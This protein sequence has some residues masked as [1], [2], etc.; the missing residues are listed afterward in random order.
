[1][2]RQLA[3]TG[4]FVGNHIR[5]IG[6]GQRVDKEHTSND[7]QRQPQCAASCFQKQYQTTKCND[8]VLGNRRARTRRKLV[9]KQIQIRGCKSGSQGKNPVVNRYV[10]NIP[11]TNHGI[12]RKR[13]ERCKGEMNG[14]CFRRVKN[15]ELNNVGER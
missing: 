9:I 5:H 11:A 1:M 12:S 6:A 4:P 13:E 14:S 2:G 15:T 7:G 8:Q 10:V 3:Q